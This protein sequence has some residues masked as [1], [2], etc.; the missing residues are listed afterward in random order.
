MS[1]EYRYT[2]DKSESGK[3]NDGFDGKGVQKLRYDLVPV[4]AL[5]AIARV[6]T[7]GS[8]KYGDN[9][10]RITEPKTR[11]IAAAFRHIESFRDGEALDPESGIHH[12]AHAACSLIFIL[13]IDL[14]NMFNPDPHGLDD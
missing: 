8:S 6:F 9:N 12:L 14:E 2:H 4:K 10:W 13:A 3:K 1:S 5:K 11:Y 7:F